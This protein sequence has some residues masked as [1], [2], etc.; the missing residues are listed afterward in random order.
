MERARI[1]PAN[2]EE[3]QQAAEIDEL[4]SGWPR[5][6]LLMMIDV[7]SA[8]SAWLI[9]RRRTTNLAHRSFEAVLVKPC[10][11]PSRDCLLGAGVAVRE[12]RPTF[13]NGYRLD[14]DGFA[15]S[16]SPKT[17]LV[18]LGSPQNPSGIRTSRAIVEMRLELLERFA[19][20]AILFIDETYREAI[21]GNESVPE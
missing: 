21:F 14:P 9:R 1:Y 18:R 7:V 2:P 11:P 6:T 8:A 19:P 20:Q 17:M 16:L 4:E 3:Q 10:L 5:M 12:I 15:K 13:E